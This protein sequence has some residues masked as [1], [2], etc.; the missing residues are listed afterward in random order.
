MI[1][2]RNPEFYTPDG[3]T[4]ILSNKDGL[5]YFY[6]NVSRVVTVCDE[7]E[8]AIILQKGFGSKKSDAVSW[9]EAQ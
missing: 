6:H 2:I 1:V 9:V 7:E 3:N 5:N 4:E 8:N